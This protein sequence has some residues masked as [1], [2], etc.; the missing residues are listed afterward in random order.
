MNK[1][2]VNS[3]CFAP[4]PKEDLKSGLPWDKAFVIAGGGGRGGFEY[5][6]KQI[7]FEDSIIYGLDIDPIPNSI[8]EREKLKTRNCW[9]D[10]CRNRF[11]FEK[12]DTPSI[13]LFNS[14]PLR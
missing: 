5:G 8:L 7:T 10:N 9:P 14:R 2:L 3:G 6:E 4:N 11:S 12:T 1:Q 13:L